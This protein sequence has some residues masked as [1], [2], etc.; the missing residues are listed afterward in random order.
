MSRQ[1]DEASVL[2]QAEYTLRVAF[3]RTAGKGPE[4]ARVEWLITET[5]RKRPIREIWN[6]ALT[7][8]HEFLRLLSEIQKRQLD[9][10]K[11]P[12]AAEPADE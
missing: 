5:I 8:E 3:R 2:D 10:L 4:W 11:K 1:L 7:K 9:E 6:V 12:S